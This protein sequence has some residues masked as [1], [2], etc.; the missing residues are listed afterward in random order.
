[1]D[2]TLPSDQTSLSDGTNW[3]CVLYDVMLQERQSPTKILEK[4]FNMN[5]IKRKQSINQNQGLF[6]KSTGLDSSQM[7]IS[8]RTPKVVGT[9]LI[10]GNERD[11]TTICNI[12]WLIKNTT[13]GTSLGAQWLR[14]CLPMRGTWVWALVREDP[15]CCGATKPVCHNYRACALEPV[16]H[17]YWARVPQLLKP[18]HLEPV[19][20]NKRSHCNEKLAHCNKE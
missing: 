1:M 14:I 18:V 2:N 10:K 15:T 6:C 12:Q 8:Q 17:N 4:R 11:L 19:L 9:V 7:S 16:S 5:H 20:C 3:R 13:I